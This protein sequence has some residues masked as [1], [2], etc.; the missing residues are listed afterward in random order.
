MNPL[1]EQA[2][3][4]VAD[5]ERLRK[6]NDKLK[7]LYEDSRKEIKSLNYDLKETMDL[8]T[9]LKKRVKDL[10]CEVFVLSSHRDLNAKAKKRTEH[11]TKLMTAKDREI[12]T[13]RDE[14]AYLESKVAN[15]MDD[16]VEITQHFIDR[17]EWIV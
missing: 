5:Y 17:E 15:L 10:D 14:V 8:N 16:K 7:E 11:Y 1:I 12:D 2:V 4:L 3:A 6:D 9:S 13:L